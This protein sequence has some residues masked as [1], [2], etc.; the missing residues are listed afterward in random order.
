MT[1]G[2]AVVL[3]TVLLGACT[4]RYERMVRVTP[5]GY[6]TARPEVVMTF[7]GE[8]MP[9]QLRRIDQFKV[10]RSDQRLTGDRLWTAEPES[11]ISPTPVP[12]TVRGRQLVLHLEDVPEGVHELWAEWDG[13]ATQNNA[14]LVVDRQPP[15][16][17]FEPPRRQGDV[18]ELKGRVSPPLGEVLWSFEGLTDVDPT[19]EGPD[20]EVVFRV[21]PT[22]P[23]QALVLTDRGGNTLR[24]PVQLPWPPG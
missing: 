19:D 4:P 5:D 8:D 12:A 9:E 24:V 10:F 23:D 15:T 16:A 17:S 20:G 18:W 2:L 1:A 6:G 14:V 7:G 21:R 13:R 11:R 3:F 22:G